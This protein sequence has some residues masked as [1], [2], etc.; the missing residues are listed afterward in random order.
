MS[1]P[2]QVREYMRKLGTIGGSVRS[3]AKTEANRLNAKK[4]RKK[5]I[6]K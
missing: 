5:R 4:P 3:A 2:T 1:I 6:S